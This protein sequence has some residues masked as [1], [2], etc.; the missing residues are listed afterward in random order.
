[1]TLTRRQFLAAASLAGA[2]AVAGYVIDAAFDH[3]PGGARSLGEIDHFVLLMQEN[4]SFDHYFGTLSGVRGFDDH[5]SVFRQY[6]WQRGVG[7][8]PHGYLLPFRLALTVGPRNDPQIINDPAHDWKT[9]HK[10]WHNGALDRWLPAHSPID[11]AN[12]PV[13][14]AYYDRADLPIH[15]RLADAFTVCDHYF[16][17]VLGPT[18]PNRLYWMTGTLDPDG[19]AGGPV[20]SAIPRGRLPAWRTFPENLQD[21]G[22]SWKV[23][24]A[25]GSRYL[26]LSG[27]VGRFAQYQDPG[28]ELYRRGVA[29]SYPHDFLR[30]VHAGRLPAV[31]WLIPPR[32]RS[33]HP[34]YPPPV[35]ADEI[36]RVL[37]ALVARPDVWERTALIVS[38]DENGGLFD[39]V[40]PPSPAAGTRGEF[41]EGAEGSVPIGLGFRVPCLVLSPY[42]R[43]GLL[44]SAVFDHT[45]QLRLL[46]A[47]FGVPVPNLSRWRI[48]TVQDMTSLLT[49]RHLR[50]GP[51]PPFPNAARDSRLAMALDRELDVTARAGRQVGYLLPPNSLPR[52]ETQPHRTVITE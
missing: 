15:H 11:G 51:T 46:G 16:C 20:T 22:V 38:Y 14:M 50:P 33:E 40:R 12:T 41:L 2:A 8:S 5:S 3:D 9:Q 1:M 26:E 39:H 25:P 48:D 34:D 29:P 19:V 36:V 30:D 23:Y 27:T 37:S 28:S 45:S 32:S 44:S 24:N 31:S 47:R 17:S 7:P 10:A 35:G 4:R 6:G 49:R 21:A 18:V 13:V 43:G 52:Q 42:T